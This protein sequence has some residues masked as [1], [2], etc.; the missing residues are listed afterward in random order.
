MSKDIVIRARDVAKMYR[1]KH[2]S[3]AR[4]A[5]L[6]D[7]V[8]DLF[9]K[10][11]KSQTN[12]EFWALN[13]VSFDIEAGQ[14]V[15]I[16]GRNGAGKSTLLKILSRITKPTQ[17]EIRVLG[18]MASLL[19]VGT[20]FHPELT[21]R[22]NIFLNGAILGM[23][24]R[25][26]RASFD[27]IVA[28]A[29]VER[30]L[31]TPVKRYSSGMQTRLGFAVAAHLKPEIL[32]VDEVLAVGDHEFQKRCLGKMHEVSQGGRTVL[33]VTHNMN[34]LGSLTSRCIHLAQG[35]VVRDGPTHEVVAQYLAG[36]EVNHPLYES[37][38]RGDT[39]KLLGVEV[40]TSKAGGLHSFLEPLEIRF[41]IWCP[42]PV[43]GACL[44]VQI[45]DLNRLSCSANP[46]LFDSEMPYARERGV[47]EV[48]CY[49]P[50]VRLFVGSYNLTVRLTEPPGGLKFDQQAGI[51]GFQVECLGKQRLEY[52]FEPGE[53]AYLE[54]CEWQV[55]PPDSD[56]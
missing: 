55:I 43:R 4:Y 30:F 50:K 39:P 13:G 2:Q 27:E 38:E 20:G 28:F 9:S 53:A 37:P 29:E 45:N 25:E 47:H 40:R 52:P 18:R 32:I 34:T 54:D 21:G 22:E 8:S 33:F 14:V 41:K 10:K 51:C 44:S 1:L 16:I 15:G 12:E 17:G 31:D 19:E 56:D 48:V 23:Q 35:K 3:K 6:R 26:V 11:E 24:Q 7:Q 49:M 42:R 5:T 46:W 36:G